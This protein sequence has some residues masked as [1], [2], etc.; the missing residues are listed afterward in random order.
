MQS[1]TLQSLTGFLA[2]TPARVR[3][4]VSDLSE[5]DARW[6]PTPQEFS[7]VEQVCHL[8]D[9]EREGYMARI[10]KLLCEEQPLLPDF[11]GGRVA[12]ERDYAAQ[13]LSAALDDF[14]VARDSNM[15]AIRGLA[16]AAL[17][18]CGTLE[19]VGP[20]TLEALLEKMREHDEGHLQELGR[21]REQLTEK[22]LH[23]AR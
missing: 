22:T 13:P 21:L 15:R 18:R 5:T 2:E 6:K 4:L 11:D 23:D 12:A 14:A 10:E 9:L 1:T 19:G 8:R 7:A 16:P 20:V 17:L 3:R